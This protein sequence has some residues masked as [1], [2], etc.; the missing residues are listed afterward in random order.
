MPNRLSEETSPYLKQHQD[1]PVDWY[2]WGDTAIS[3]AQ[4]ANKPIFLS[5]GYAACHWCHVMA[6]ESF[7]DLE[8]AEILNEHFVSIKVDREERPDLDD[9]YMQSVVMITGQG[10]WPMSVFLTPQLKPFF[11][12]TYFP[13]EPRYGMPSFKQVLR[14]VVDA[15]HTKRPEIDSNADQIIQALEQ[16]LS[17]QVSAPSSFDFEG[18]IDA[19]YNQYDWEFGGWGRAPK[20]PPAMLV[21]FLLQRAWQG[22]P[23]AREMSEHL[24][25]H[26]ALGGMYDLVGGGFHRY[27]VDRQWLVPHFE[28]MLYDNALLAQAYIDGFVITGKPRYRHVAV[29]TLEFVQQEMK[30]PHGGFYSSLDA[31]TPEGEGRY[32]TWA[33][34]DLK[35][36]LSPSEF[37]LLNQL[38]AIQ[39]Q[40]NFEDGLNALQFRKPLNIL[41]ADVGLS[42]E[43]LQ[44]EL[45][46]I[47]QKLYQ[48]RA[49][50]IPPAKDTKIILS[51]NAL[52]IRTFIKAGLFLAR[53][54]FIQ[55]GQQALAFI[56]N[57]MAA[58][59]GNLSRVWHTG[60]ANQPA[61][62]S[63]TAGLILAL[64]ASYEVDF[65]PQTFKTMRQLYARM[66][67]DFT[68][69]TT[70]YFDSSGN[71]E[72]LIIRPKS[73]QDNALPS[74]NALAAHVHWLLWN[75][76]DNQAHHERLNQML[77]S[78]ADQANRYP[79]H[80]GYWLQVADRHAHTTAQIAL[81][82]EN[83][84]DS[85]LPFLNAIRPI[86]HPYRT[87]AAKHSETSPNSELPGIL[88]GKS[89]IESQPTAYVC[90]D[91][92]CKTPLTNV[93][94]LLRQI[95]NSSD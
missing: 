78:V 49:R 77:L 73:L 21:T 34:D 23:R 39:P 82:T 62:L 22:D 42:L 88:S 10:G 8:T 37:D 58:S 24:L 20:F 89:P 75:L 61:A 16:Q 4:Q 12:G 64:Q 43:K 40:G 69:E 70:F 55:S 5:I 66:H 59:S 84:L 92:T 45:I 6:H 91:F 25:D 9:I 79:N 80:F 85:L 52:A 33:Y 74:G 87:L 83:G 63:D 46:G 67:S 35:S 27:S 94:D 47:Y 51:W 17:N 29:R 7:E 26:M 11:G 65:S 68:P 86:Y 18:I 71:T 81:V 31:D 60:R 57:E 3:R 76:D 2:P 1:N 95:A 44:A 48:L 15:W 54:D 14:S 93:D 50:R 53:E 36:S 56:L 32:Y 13:P 90:E 38:M 72:H 41:A 19:L 30:A 28:K